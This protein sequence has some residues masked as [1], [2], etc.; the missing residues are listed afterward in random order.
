MSCMTLCFAGENERLAKGELGKSLD[1]IGFPIARREL[2]PLACSI[3]NHAWG[4]R[5]GCLY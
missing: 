5:R 4:G 1:S 3:V 2:V